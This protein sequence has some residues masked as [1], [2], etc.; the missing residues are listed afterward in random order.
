[1]TPDYV[2]TVR[3]LLAIASTVFASDRFAMKGGTALNLFV[4][5]MPRLSIHRG[6]DTDDLRRFWTSP[7]DHPGPPSCRA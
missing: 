7:N 4:Q 6:I 2:D 1:M 3:L 5:D